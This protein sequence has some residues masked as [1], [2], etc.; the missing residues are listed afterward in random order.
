VD[1]LVEKTINAAIETG[2]KA[3]AVTGGV[4]SN[5]YLRKRMTEKALSEGLRCF[6]PD[7]KFCTDN[8]AMVAFSGHHQLK[9]GLVLGPDADV[10]SRLPA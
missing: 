7:E 6:V 9:A 4:A 2:V 5:S 3:V 1:I 8:A 10:Y